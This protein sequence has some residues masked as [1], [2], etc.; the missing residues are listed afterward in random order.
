M[1]CCLIHIFVF[2]VL[3]C[4]GIILCLLFFYVLQ[5]R[6]FPFAVVV[7]KVAYS[8]RNSF[9]Y[10]VVFLSLKAIVVLFTHFRGTPFICD[11][12]FS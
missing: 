10:L 3:M 7:L 12:G 6:H 4:L 5:G 11:C 2:L 8:H 9:V 1:C